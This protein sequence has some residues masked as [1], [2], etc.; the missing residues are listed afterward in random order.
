MHPFV[1]RTV[2][3]AGAAALAM[4]AS[5]AW[6]ANYASSSDPTGDWKTYTSY[7][8]KTARSSI[9][10]SQVTLSID[11]TRV[12]VKVRMRDVVAATTRDHQGLT[13]EF[14]NGSGTSVGSIQATTDGTP[15]GYCAGSTTRCPN[16]TKSYSTTYNWMTVSVPRSQ[17]GGSYLRAK[18]GTYLWVKNEMGD[19]ASGDPVA[20]TPLVKK[21]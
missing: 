2:A 11:S 10:A 5:P 7:W 4:T 6:A 14:R 12:Y 20:W 1:R 8:T 13:I 9:D 17:L 19:A 18:V 3:V 15:R 21:P 16:I